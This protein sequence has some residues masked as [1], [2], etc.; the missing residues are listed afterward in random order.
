MILKIFNRKREK[1]D[2]ILGRCQ[3]YLIPGTYRLSLSEDVVYNTRTS[4]SLSNLTF[5]SRLRT[6]LIRLLANRFINI[7][8]KKTIRHNNNIFSGSEVLLTSNRKEFKV[9]DYTNNE[10][11]TLFSDLVKQTK[12][13]E[14]KSFFS[15]YF[16]VPKTIAFIPDKYYQKEEFIMHVPYNLNFA[17]SDMLQKY[18][19]YCSSNNKIQINNNYWKE[20]RERFSEKFGDSLLLKELDSLPLLFT[21]GDLWSSNVIYDGNLYYITDFENGAYRY[22]G[23]DLM[24]FICSEWIINKESYLIESY[25]SGSWDSHFTKIMQIYSLPFSSRMKRILL[26]AFIVTIYCERWFV[27]DEL[28]GKVK[29]YIKLYIPNY[30]D[31]L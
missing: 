6:G 15:N 7:F 3:F 11:V 27:S 23:Y 16:N 8:V 31:K 29:S 24:T 21:H 18:I 17:F 4:S 25:L 30:F 10:V 14:N 12:I 19:I 22:F 13:E 5:T 2:Y 28:D 26:L 20:K 1:L 9:F